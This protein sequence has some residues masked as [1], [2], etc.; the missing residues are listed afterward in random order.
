MRRAKDVEAGAFVDDRLAAEPKARS[1]KP[2]VGEPSSLP[3]RLFRVGA[4]V[5][6][7]Y[8]VGAHE[9]VLAAFTS[10]TC[11]PAIVRAGGN[12]TCDVRTGALSSDADLS[13]TQ[14]GGAGRIVLLS[15]SA[16]AY[17]VSFST[18]T[19]GAAGVRVSH[20]I[21]W[22]SAA[23]EVLAGPA[24]SVDVEC[25]P[26]RAAPGKE[27][28]CAVTP[29]D[30]F[31]NAAEVEKPAGAP[32]NYFAVSAVGDA[33]NLVVHDTDVSFTLGGEAGSRAGIAVTLDGRRVESTVEVAAPG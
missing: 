16:H 23:V 25:A 7:C 4:A 3:V 24:R 12:A 22:S 15:E 21:F 27:V 13:I 1:D 28:R 8:M 33:T 18:R 5:A 29:R 20:S 31:G 30:A 9:L 10:V 19:A 11:A 2:K 6:A 14:T 17:R 26:A 32:A